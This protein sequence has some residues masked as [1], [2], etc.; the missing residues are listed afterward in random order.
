MADW[1]SSPANGAPNNTRNTMTS[2]C[3]LDPTT[4][5]IKNNILFLMWNENTFLLAHAAFKARALKTLIGGWS[6]HQ[7]FG[8]GLRRTFSPSHVVQP[9]NQQAL[10][11]HWVTA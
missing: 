2:L 11:I 7:G 5:K 1:V 10:G 4:N 8:S 3:G 6:E 9:K